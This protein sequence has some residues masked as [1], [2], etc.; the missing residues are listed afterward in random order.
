MGVC[1]EIIRQEKTDRHCAMKMIFTILL[2]L[3]AGIQ[4]GV[5][6]LDCLTCEAKR[7]QPL[8][9]TRPEHD[10]TYKECEK[11]TTY[12]FKS[13]DRTTKEVNKG[14]LRPGELVPDS[15][16]ESD[17]EMF[18]CSGQLCNTASI[19]FPALSLL[20]VSTF[21]SALVL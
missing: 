3:L 4:T 16:T 10:G 9:C 11:G 7:S 5:L 18:L 2:V 21:L 6:S 17:Q 1:I 8:R 12:C 19:T 14:C 13:V 15:K 20:G